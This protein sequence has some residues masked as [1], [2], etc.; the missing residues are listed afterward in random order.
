MD[1]SSFEIMITLRGIRRVLSCPV[2]QARPVSVME[3]RRIFS[4]IN[5]LDSQDVA[6]WLAI[7]LCFRG[8]L[9]KSNVCEVGLAVL[10]RDLEFHWW[11]V[12]LSVRRSKTICFGERVLQVPFNI[13]PDSIFCVH[14]FCKLLFKLVSYPDVDSQLISYMSGARCVRAS[15]SWF[16]NRLT[17]TCAR[18]NLVRLTSHSLRRGCATSLADAGFS[19][20]DI[21]N[22]G[23]WASLSVLHYISKTLD[24]KRVLDMKL[25]DNLFS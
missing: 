15:Y 11:G 9:R 7:L 23:D 19:V 25:C 12:L 18:L 21:R 22:L 1:P 16:S 8:L 20:L 3:L 10:V 5:L 14:R 4:T 17:V 2:R 24:S 13:L 6:F